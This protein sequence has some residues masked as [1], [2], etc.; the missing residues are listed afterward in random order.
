MSDFNFN[1]NKILVKKELD[2]YDGETSIQVVGAVYEKPFMVHQ[3]NE[4]H[5]LIAFVNTDT[6]MIYGPSRSYA[7]NTE[8]ELE[9]EMKHISENI[10]D[11]KQK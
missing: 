5:S 2:L 1:D 4:L 8:A 3:S 10:K 7:F 11:Y 6:N 9:S